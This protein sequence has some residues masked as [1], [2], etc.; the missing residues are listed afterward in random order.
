M[1]STTDDHINE[2]KARRQKRTDDE[3]PP[4]SNAEAPPGWKPGEQA[5]DLLRDLITNGP[6]QSQNASTQANAA[7]TSASRKNLEQSTSD[8][9]ASFNAQTIGWFM[10]STWPSCDP[11]RRY[12]HRWGGPG[13]G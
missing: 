9:S 11:R 10:S 12:Q 2:L 7:S 5:S 3:Q 6:P 1:S 4:T 13:C 8:A